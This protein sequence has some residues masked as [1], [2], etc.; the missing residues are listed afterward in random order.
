M[1]RLKA[2]DLEDVGDGVKEVFRDLEEELG[3]VPNVFRTMAHSPVVLRAYV[4]FLD[5][6]QQGVLS[7]RLRERIALA[8]SQ[9]ND[10]PYSLAEHCA[11]ALAA[12]LSK[13]EISDSRKAVSPDRRVEAAL[14]FARKVARGLQSVDGEG[15]STLKR[16]GFSDEEIAEIIASIVLTIFK[17]YF[18]K[19]A[20]TCLD[21][22]KAKNIEA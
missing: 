14:S 22:P 11:T 7:E 1:H 17:N 6:L 16:V 18:N 13:E 21:Y 4:N 9:V 2:L 15:V 10:C 20:G 8:V 12:G 19:L 5:S 3:M